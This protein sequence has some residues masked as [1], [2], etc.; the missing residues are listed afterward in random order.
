MN[1]CTYIYTSVLIYKIEQLV[2]L[3]SRTALPIWEN[4]IDLYYIHCYLISKIYETDMFIKFEAKESAG[5]E[6]V[7]L[8]MRTTDNHLVII[9]LSV[10]MQP[11]SIWGVVPR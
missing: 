6:L 10:E 9:K 1:L 3:I 8:Y 7:F 4:S 5:V 2:C 11:C